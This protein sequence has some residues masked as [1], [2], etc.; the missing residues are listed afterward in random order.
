MATNERQPVR[1]WNIVQRADEDEADVYIFGDITSFRWIASDVSAFSLVNE[2]KQ[3]TASRINVHINSYGG[4][5]AEGLAIYNVLHDAHLKGK[6]VKTWCD[7]FACS[8]ASVIFMAG[9]SR[10]MSPVSLLMIHNAS[11]GVYGTPAELQKAA[12]DLETITSASV[13]AY[14]LATGMDEDKIKAMMDAETWIK[15]DDA[16]SMGFATE[17]SGVG[18]VSGPSQSA[19]RRVFEALS[20]ALFDGGQPQAISGDQIKLGTIRR[21]Q[22]PQ[23]QAPTPA[24]EPKSNRLKGFLRKQKGE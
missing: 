1:Y 5:V 18:Q 6:T 2:L 13:E 8:A 7:G 3:L 12:D 19:Q 23:E 21:D 16:L 11:M 22:M 15:P 24:T 10:I 9:S 17:I 20:S 4:E 14:K